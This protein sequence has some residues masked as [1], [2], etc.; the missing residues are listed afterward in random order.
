MFQHKQACLAHRYYLTQCDGDLSPGFGFWIL[1][2]PIEEIVAPRRG[3][4]A[5]CPSADG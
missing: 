5:G 2:H 3:G 4:D 1:G